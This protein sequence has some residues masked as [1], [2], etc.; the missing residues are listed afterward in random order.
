M[1]LSNPMSIDP[2]QVTAAAELRRVD[3][4]LPPSFDRQ[5]HFVVPGSSSNPSSHTSSFLQP[6]ADK[7]TVPQTTFPFPPSSRPSRMAN[8]EYHTDLFARSYDPSLPPP[9][10]RHPGHPN[11]RTQQALQQQSLPD[12]RMENYSRGATA[13]FVYPV[14]PASYPHVILPRQQLQ[15]LISTQ[16]VNV[17]GI[18]PDHGSFNRVDGNMMGSHD[19]V[20]HEK[21]ASE[22]QQYLHYERRPSS[23]GTSRHQG[24]SMAR[25][26]ERH[27]GQSMA[28][29][30][31]R[32]LHTLEYFS[33]ELQALCPQDAT[34]Y[35]QDH[36]P[37]IDSQMDY[38]IKHPGSPATVLHLP[39]RK[40]HV[41]TAATE[42]DPSSSGCPD[43]LR[44]QRYWSGGALDSGHFIR[45]LPS[46][47]HDHHP[48]GRAPRLH[49]FS[50]PNCFFSAAEVSFF[51]SLMHER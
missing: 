19:D 10:V 2:I 31:E 6:A 23:I 29:S 51:E 26:F 21:P 7:P 42:T 38:S 34:R 22:G 11:T 47:S 15:P 45:P 46:S 44:S 3:P 49:R 48:H 40:G 41:D 17:S 8:V 27:Q 16:V 33:S 35:H 30:F 9:T 28:R 43:A 18:H 14:S 13:S 32:P 25:S 39:M 20:F 5:Q 4:G 1:S 37:Q 12:A 24:Q 50:E 36:V